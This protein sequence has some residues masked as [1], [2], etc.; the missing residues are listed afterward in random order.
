MRGAGRNVHAHTPIHLDV[1]VR[2]LDLLQ[3]MYVCRFVAACLCS[4]C[5]CSFT[6]RAWRFLLLFI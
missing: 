1:L 3:G 6:V 2:C 4:Y 5:F